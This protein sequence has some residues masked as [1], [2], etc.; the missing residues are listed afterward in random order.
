MSLFDCCKGLPEVQAEP[1][2][3]LLTEGTTSGKL[4][5]LI[6]GELQVLRGGV[7]VATA[8]DPGA[9]FGEMSILLD[10][11]HTAT[12]R[13]LTPCRLYVVDDTEGFLAAAPDMMRHIGKLLAHRLQL[14]TGYLADLKSQFAES[15]NHLGML[16]TVLESLLHQ[17]EPGFK[18][19]GSKRGADPRL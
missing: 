19:G 3:V 11:P 10:I 13:A 12:V 18:P 9:V 6:E 7:E 1:G 17:Q 16:D 14:A 5:V 4:Y 15:G 8:A 2:T